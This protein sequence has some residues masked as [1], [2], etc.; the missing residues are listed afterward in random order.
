MRKNSIEITNKNYETYPLW[1]KITIDIMQSDKINSFR[2]QKKKE[3]YEIWGANQFVKND[4][5]F[6]LMFDENYNCWLQEYGKIV[7]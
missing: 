5:V 4:I 6:W 7:A 3:G 2:D 1:D